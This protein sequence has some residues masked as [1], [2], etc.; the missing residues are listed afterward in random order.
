MGLLSAIGGIAGS[1]FGGPIGGT[2]GSSLG[3]M[4]EG[5]EAAGQASSAQQASYDAGIAEH[6]RQYDIMRELMKP[7]TEAG[8]PAL[9]AQ[10]AMLGL[11]PAG[12]E[13]AQIEAVK[14]SPTYLAMLGR[15]EESLL[16]RASATGGLRG[17]N[18]QAA[19][20]QF[21][22]QLL[23]QELE[24]RYNR[25]GG[26]A[27]LGQSSAAGV[28]GDGMTTGTNIAN[29]LAKQGAAQA[30]GIVSQQNAMNIPGLFGMAQG[31]GGFG[32]IFSNPFGGGGT[33]SSYGT[34]PGSQQ[35]QMLAAQD[36]GF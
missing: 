14:R 31:Y 28:G 11:G 5:Q 17:G 33:A 8:V 21:S 29:L 15:G 34:V 1:F 6:R 23:A 30:G 24:N 12:S 26:L 19:L 2:I 10:Q 36:Y 18:I 22:P 3:G 4:I 25:L 13:Q 27:S 20:A 9:Q 7:Y 32:N 16:Q 35:T